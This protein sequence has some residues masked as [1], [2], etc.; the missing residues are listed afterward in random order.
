MENSSLQKRKFVYCMEPNAY[1]IAPCS[2]CGGR[3]I[4]WSEFKDYLWCF[5]CSI[6]FIPEHYGIFDGP[7]PIHLCEMMGTKFDRIEIATKKRFKREDPD[8][9]TTFNE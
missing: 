8:Y 7:I 1:D 4:T 6:D 9:N 2:K 5:D 3:N